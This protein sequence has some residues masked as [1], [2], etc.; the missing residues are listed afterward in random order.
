MRFPASD[1]NGRIAGKAHAYSSYFQGIRRGDAYSGG[2]V[3][4]SLKATGTS[5]ELTNNHFPGFEIKSEK[6]EGTG[7]FGSDVLLIP[8]IVNSSQED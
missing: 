6:P 8:K 2:R 7:I 3:A 5:I 4:A 1:I